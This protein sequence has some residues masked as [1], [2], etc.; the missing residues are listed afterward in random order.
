MPIKV[1]KKCSPAHEGKKRD[2]VVNIIQ[3]IAG[4]SY[5]TMAAVK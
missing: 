3:N 2:I 4:P 1:N 5:V